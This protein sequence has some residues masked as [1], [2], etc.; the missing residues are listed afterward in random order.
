MH[1]YKL[2]L[3]FYF[4]KFYI[5]SLKTRVSLAIRYVHIFTCLLL[6]NQ[7]MLQLNILK[8]PLWNYTPKRTSFG[9]HL[10]SC[11][12]WIRNKKP[13]FG[14]IL[15]SNLPFMELAP[16]RLRK[17]KSDQ[18]KKNYIKEVRIYWRKRSISMVNCGLE[19]WWWQSQ[20]FDV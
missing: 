15:F 11:Q 3:K 9:I 18:R 17:W 13:T 19:L 10:V 2:F 1:T 12:V 16:Q 20:V 8:R 5:H 7:P 14:G 6:K 4:Q